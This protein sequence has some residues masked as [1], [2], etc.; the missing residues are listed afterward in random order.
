MFDLEVLSPAFVL[1]IQT[2][3]SEARF[4]IVQQIVNTGLIRLPSHKSSCQMTCETAGMRRV[5]ITVQGNPLINCKVLVFGIV[6][7]VR[8]IDRL[9]CHGKVAQE[10]DFYR[11]ILFVTGL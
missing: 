1:T 7:P 3:Q 10:T 2:L 8:Y 6:F 4:N 11:R 9:G 5:P